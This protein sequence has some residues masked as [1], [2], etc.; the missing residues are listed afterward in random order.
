MFDKLHP[1]GIT[2]AERF[3]SA[4]PRPEDADGDQLSETLDGRPGPHG[5]VFLCQPHSPLMTF[6]CPYVGCDPTHPAHRLRF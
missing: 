1:Q 3:A 4:R 5:E 2:F 6:A